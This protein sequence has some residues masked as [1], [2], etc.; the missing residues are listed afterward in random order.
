M[1]MEQPS[2]E[3]GGGAKNGLLNRGEKVKEQRVGAR[4]GGRGRRRGGGRGRGRG[5]KVCVVRM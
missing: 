3:S 4:V 1:I 2:P 5:G